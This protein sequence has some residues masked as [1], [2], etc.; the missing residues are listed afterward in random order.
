MEHAMSVLRT[1]FILPHDRP[2]VD[3]A[4]DTSWPQNGP[5]GRA[6]RRMWDA[7]LRTYFSRCHHVTVHGIEHLPAHGPMILVANHA[8]HL[9]AMLL[10]AVLPPHWRRRVFPIAA[11]DTFFTRLTPPAFAGRMM[12]A[13]PL[14]RGPRRHAMEQLR[15]R[16]L[17]D[18]CAYMFF[19]EG[20]RSRTGH[21][22]PFH[23][24]IGMLVAN[25]R[26]PVIPC[27]ISGTFHAWPPGTLIPRRGTLSV[28]IGRPHAFPKMQ[29][30][31]AGWDH[32]ATTL[33]NAVKALSIDPC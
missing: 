7:A 9:D 10:A 22:H 33:E 2:E 23:A 24:G 20:T 29:N 13:L 14:P 31:R 32:I 8:S 19:P 30:T 11:A 4:P 25:T 21:M 6:V 5:L 18:R 1:D 12:N 26:T 3:A 28:H 16:L 15:L 17:R 27:H